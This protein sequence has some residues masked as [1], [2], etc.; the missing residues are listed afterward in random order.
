MKKRPSWSGEPDDLT[1]TKGTLMTSNSKVIT[2]VPRTV[3]TL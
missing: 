2:K 3:I 1:H